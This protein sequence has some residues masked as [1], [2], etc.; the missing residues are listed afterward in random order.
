MISCN[1]YDYIEIACMHRYPI[2]ITLKT[3][4]EVD[5]IALDTLRND[6]GEECIK[7][8]IN[9]LE[10]FVVLDAIASLQIRIKNPHFE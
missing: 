1:E 2:R 8:N 4:Q 5:C 10:S 9:D 6:A 7:V 3:G